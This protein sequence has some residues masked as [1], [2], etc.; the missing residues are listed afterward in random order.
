MRATPYERFAGILAIL[1]GAAGL[2]Y[3]VS[4]VL[5]G[6]ALLSALFL[7]L[8][9]LF[10]SAALVALYQRLSPAEP[11]FGLWALLLGLVAA[12]GS[13]LHGSYDLA[14]VLHPPATANLDL[15]SQV[16]PRGALTFGLAGVSLLIFAW[17]ILKTRQ[18]APGLGYL[19][20]VSAILLI[21]IYLGRLVVLQATSP[22]ILVPA[23][24]EGFLVNPIWYVWLG[25]ALR[26]GG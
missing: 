14:N 6:N 21:L 9:G 4:F 25:V 24:I 10:A 12:A 11:G 17:L 15:P 26:R 13:F 7:L 20:L 2:L 5:L 16:D 18:L 22:L 8:G 19:G 3:S 1:A 23:A